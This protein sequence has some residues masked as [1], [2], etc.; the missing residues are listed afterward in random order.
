MTIAMVIDSDALLT[1]PFD[2]DAFESTSG[3]LLRDSSGTEDCLVGRGGS[4]SVLGLRLSLSLLL[5]EELG[6]SLDLRDLEL[7]FL[8]I[9]GRGIARD[10]VKVCA[11]LLTQD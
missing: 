2:F 5:P 9:F 7:N 1:A 11:V 10:G 6:R 8:R 3:D 4:V